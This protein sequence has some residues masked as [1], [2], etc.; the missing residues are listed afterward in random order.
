MAKDKVHFENCQPILRVED[1]K[2]SLRFYMDALGFKNASWGNDDFTHVNRDSA[3]IYLCRGD[4]GLGKAWIWIGVEDVV[5]L[6]EE[7]ASSKVKIRME[8]RNFP[9]A[10]EMHVED[11][12]GNIIRFGS[13]PDAAA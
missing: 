12:D 5:Q 11:P 4:Q 7:Y 2:I 1:M 13:E 10:K 6:R 9:W 8:P 3:G